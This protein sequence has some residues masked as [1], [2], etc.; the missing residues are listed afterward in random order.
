VLPLKYVISAVAD[1]VEGETRTADNTFVDGTVTILP[2]PPFFPTL[3]WLIFSIIVV[4]AIIAGII[5]LFLL[6]ASDR[7][8]RRRTRPVYTVIAHPHI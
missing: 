2:Y 1:I 5:L 6:F 3:D 8:R 7:M 4:I